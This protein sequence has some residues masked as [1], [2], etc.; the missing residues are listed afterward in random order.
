MEFHSICPS[1]A[2]SYV[3]GTIYYEFFIAGNK[4][5]R[6]GGVIV[7]NLWQLR[8]C[9]IFAREKNNKKLITKN[10]SDACFKDVLITESA[11]PVLNWT[12]A[13]EYCDQSGGYLPVISNKN[14][15]NHILKERTYP[16][17]TSEYGFQLAHIILKFQWQNPKLLR[18]G[19]VLMCS[20]RISNIAGKDVG[21]KK[22]TDRSY[23]GL[24][25]RG[26]KDTWLPINL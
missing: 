3:C 18:I 12:E 8:L 4:M 22:N 14:D 1:L 23:F 15:R 13:V 24:E 19:T 6:F 21:D 16:F 7:F 9:V 5:Y 11:Y 25:W 17:S 26:K 10:Y 20:I 2:I